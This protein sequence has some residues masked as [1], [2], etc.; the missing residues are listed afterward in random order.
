[1]EQITIHAKLVAEQTD[2]MGYTNYV[3]EDI[4]SKDNDFKYVM[5]V[6]FPNWEQGPIN[7]ND[8]G[9]LNIRYVEEGVD[10]WFDGTNFIPYKYTNIIFIKFIK[11]KPKVDIKEIIINQINYYLDQNEEIFATLDIAI[12]DLYNGKMEFIKNGACPTYIKNK[13]K[14]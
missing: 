4:E 13:K 12:I 6:R 10:K 1:M 14:G 9:Y 11:E 2:G 3:F 7:L 5:C 8:I